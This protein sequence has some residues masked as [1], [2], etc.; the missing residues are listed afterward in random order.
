ME[1]L[2]A[3]GAAWARGRAVESVARSWRLL[4]TDISSTVAHP[5][6]VR[7]VTRDGEPWFVLA[8]VC[9]VWGLLLKRQ[10]SSKCIGR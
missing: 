4:G 5:W 2:G 7:T 10:A 6:Q 8:D 3:A 1:S 9:R